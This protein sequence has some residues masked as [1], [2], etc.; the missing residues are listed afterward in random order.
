MACGAAGLVSDACGVPVMHGKDGL[1]V[2][3]AD[4]AALAHALATLATQRDLVLKLGTAAAATARGYG[5]DRFRRH[6]VEVLRS[7]WGVSRDE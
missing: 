3:A 2:A 6:M 1:V 7:A 4:T 5:W